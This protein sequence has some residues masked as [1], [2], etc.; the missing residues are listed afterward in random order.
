VFRFLLLSAGY[1]S[2]VS[3]KVRAFL[4]LDVVCRPHYT[5]IRTFLIV[6]FIGRGNIQYFDTEILCSHYVQCILIR[7][8]IVVAFA[9]HGGVTILSS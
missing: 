8:F 9:G 7:A 2:S 5:I 3:A 4:H 1:F 6:A